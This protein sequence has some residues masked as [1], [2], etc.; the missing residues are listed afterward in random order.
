MNLAH[1]DVKPSNILISPD[2]NVKLTDFDLARPVRASIVSS[3]VGTLR[4]LPPECFRPNFG[5]CGA[6]AEKADIWMVGIVYYLT[7]FG[8]HP[9]CNDKMTP[10]EAKVT[11][12]RFRGELQY[13][14]PVADISRW[15]CQS[16]LHP[17]P[18]CRPTASQLLI[19]LRMMLEQLQSQ[20]MQM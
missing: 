6:T 10:E 1:Y 7:L 19:G 14:T 17:D 16:C 12:G 2:G 4:Y 15:I 3:S 18:R 8:K 9:V 13:P 20:Q 11:L 5:N